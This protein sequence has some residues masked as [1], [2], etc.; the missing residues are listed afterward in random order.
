MDVD[1]PITQA[2][3]LK[4]L[5]TSTDPEEKRDGQILKMIQEMS[6]QISR[7][8]SRGTSAEFF[9]AS[10]ESDIHYGGDWTTRDVRSAA[11]INAFLSK[12][13]AYRQLDEAHRKA[14]R[15]RCLEMIKHR[16]ALRAYPETPFRISNPA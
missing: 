2:V 15:K 11:Q 7:L 1:N 6:L 5:D 14:L 8:S 16:K 4:A 9:E 3:K 10:G 13:E 12:S